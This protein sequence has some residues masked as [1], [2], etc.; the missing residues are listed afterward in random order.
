MKSDQIAK[1]LAPS[2]SVEQDYRLSVDDELRTSSLIAE[3]FHFVKKK[4]Y[5]FCSDNNQIRNMFRYA[6]SSNNTRK[7]F[8]PEVPKRFY[9]HKK[10]FS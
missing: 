4:N 9:A 10:L 8:S 6:F 3:T 1:S 5:C 2:T 7:K